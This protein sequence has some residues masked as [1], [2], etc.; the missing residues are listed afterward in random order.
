ME[1]SWILV[2]DSNAS[3]RNHHEFAERFAFWLYNL[4]YGGVDSDVQIDNKIVDETLLTPVKQM[5]E[6]V[7]VI[8]EQ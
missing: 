1:W 2:M 6:I 3:M 5:S 7:F 4:I 8:T